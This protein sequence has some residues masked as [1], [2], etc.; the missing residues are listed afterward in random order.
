MLLGRGINQTAGCPTFLLLLLLLLFI[1]IFCQLNIETI[2]ISVILSN[3]FASCWYQ[4]KTG[5]FKNLKIA[6]PPPPPGPPWL[7]PE[8]DP[9]T[10]RTVLQKI[11][12]TRKY[13]DNLWHPNRIHYDFILTFSKW[14]DI[15][16]FNGRAI[17]AYPHPLELS[18]PT[19]NK[20]L[21]FAVVLRLNV[22]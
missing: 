3:F 18:G 4:D 2:C 16:K 1:N 19:I 11:T 17:N 6:I 15:K 14:E 21:F 8:I 12:T 13:A 10:T 5:P 22:K 9:D 20:I 7:Y